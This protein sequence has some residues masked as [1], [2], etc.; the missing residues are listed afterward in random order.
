MFCV[1]ADTLDISLKTFSTLTQVVISKD[2]KL[3]LG[4]YVTRSF[5]LI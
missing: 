4:F 3:E 5:F 1:I 2:W